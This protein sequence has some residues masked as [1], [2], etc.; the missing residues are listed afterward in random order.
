MQA[1]FGSWKSPI[2][3]DLIASKAI[4]LGQIALE[5][6]DVYWIESRPNEEGRSVI[7]RRS[8]DGRISDVTP[9]G[10]NARTRVHEYG[11]GAF[12]VDQ[13]A[14]YFSNWAD[15]RLYRQVQG[16]EPSPLTPPGGNLRF[17]DGVI[18]RRRRRIISVCE[19]HGS[20][21]VDNYLAGIAL[22]GSQ[23][24]QKLVS[25]HD[26]YAAPRISPDGSQ[27]AWLQWDHPN[28]PW[29]SCEL[30]LGEILTDGS[31]GHQQKIAGGKDESVCQPE[32][33]P[34]GQ[35]YFVSDRSGW[36]NLYVWRNEQAEAAFK[37]AAEL[38]EPHWVFAQSR[39]G[40][41]SA[42]RIICS[43]I[44]NGISYLASLDLKTHR[45]SSIETDYT[46][47]SYVQVG[48]QKAAF[49]AGSPTTVTGVVL[50]DLKTEKSEVL[51]SSSSLEV[52]A[53]YV[54]MPRSIEYPTE[55]GLS[56]NAFFYSPHNAEFE[57][58]AEQHPPLLVMS[59]GGPTSAVANTLN[60]TIQYWTSRGW[61]VVNVNYG[62]SSGYGRAYRQ[63]LNG[64][65][66][67]VDVQDC[68]NAARYLVNQD[69]VDP[70]RVA[71]RGGS[72]GGYTTLAALTFHDFFKAGASYYGVSDLEA[73]EKDTHKFE[74]RY[75]DTL[76]GP[77]PQQRQLFLD[78]SPVNHVDRLSSPIIFFQGT[79]DKVVPPAQ[80]E[81]MVNA[82]RLKKIPV[83]YLLFDHEQHG[84][85][86]AQNIKRSLEA[87]M[88]FY[89]KIFGFE[90]ADTIEPVEIE[91]L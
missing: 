11:G 52:N 59:H 64:Q 51:R 80:S 30:W 81:L 48:A 45:L 41:A 20:T 83:A 62:G 78:R 13:G 29:D 90:V 15:Q 65:W 69:E 63:R 44:R 72:A 79:E 27:L 10:Y 35:L 71:I 36:W 37:I 68:L 75:L 12:L 21:V 9:P 76:V 28:M 5:D 40:F 86:I 89:A 17:A 4:G 26:F 3:S 66:G 47:I 38:G 54:S 46:S 49:L 84:F 77:Y 91:N 34:D 18:D 53:K 67:L 1:P 82:L 23:K 32:F 43:F 85:R 16:S 55:N 57:G 60:L 70:A 58:L 19:E 50:F 56:S 87:E 61:A 31:I 33:S 7:V 14:V 2:T 24:I 42:R 22:D 74:S 73:L 8:A 39:Y 25:G 88:Y 6:D